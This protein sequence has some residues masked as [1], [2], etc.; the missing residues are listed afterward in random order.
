MKLK[1]QVLHE[2]IYGTT[3]VPSLGVWVV[4][5]IVSSTLSPIVS[6]C[7]LNKWHG[8]WLLGDDRDDIDLCENGH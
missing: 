7:V 3:K 8:Y 2:P 5:E 1:F 4:V 6:P